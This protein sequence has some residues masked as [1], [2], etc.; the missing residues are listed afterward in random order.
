MSGNRATVLHFE[1]DDGP[2]LPLRHVSYTDVDYAGD[3]KDRKSISAGIQFVNGMVAGWH[4]KI[5]TAV[6]L[7][8]AEAEFVSAAIGG[9]EVLWIKELVVE[10]GVQV[11][12]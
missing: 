1:P 5:Q 7:L 6:A 3:K 9:V 11:K 12:I 10:I 2:H 4:C 8:T